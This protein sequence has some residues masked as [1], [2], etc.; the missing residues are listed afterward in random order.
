MSQSENTG[1][2][3]TINAYYEPLVNSCTSWTNLT[4]VLLFD[5]MSATV[6]R[7]QIDELG[8]VASTSRL[9][10]NNGLLTTSISYSGICLV[11]F[12]VGFLMSFY[13]NIKIKWQNLLLEHL[14]FIAVLA[15]YEYFFYI[16][17]IYKY[18]TISTPELNKYIIDGLFQCAGTR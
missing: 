15:L 10:F 9:A 14:A 7:T 13:K 12:L 4:R 3:N 17:I 2:L 16:S 1:I 18:S 6:N 8:V 11:V 5:V